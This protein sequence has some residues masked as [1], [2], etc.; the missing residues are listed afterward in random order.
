MYT[1]SIAQICFVFFGAVSVRGECLIE[2]DFH[3]VVRI[4][5]GT[6]TIGSF[7]FW[8]CEK[9]T[10]VII[11]TSVTN[12]EYDAF[13]NNHNLETVFFEEM[14]QALITRLLQTAGILLKGSHLNVI[15]DYAFYANEKLKNINIPSKATIESNAFHNTGCKEE[16]FTPGAIIVDCVSEVGDTGKRTLRK[17]GGN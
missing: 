15:N 2:P 3:G 5:D 17:K 8:N 14:S 16:S 10:A 13:S 9:L 6:E 1:T 12:I 4:P 7:A 11:S